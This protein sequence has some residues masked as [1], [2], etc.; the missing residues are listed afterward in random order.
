MKALNL[1]TATLIVTVSLFCSQASAQ[2]KS[3]AA[4][5]Q[6]QAGLEKNKAHQAEMKK[7]YDAMS[8]A[9]QAEARKRADEYKK[10][11]YKN[12]SAKGSTSTTPAKKTT[13]APA[14]KPAQKSV[15][16]AKPTQG[17]PAATANQGTS[18][19]KP[20]FLDANGKPL[21]TTS[22][23][24]NA[25]PATSPSKTTPPAKPATSQ[26]EKAVQTAPSAGSIKK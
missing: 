19:T 9:E 2:S 17:K 14:T 11:G 26:T 22:P 7:K 12:K 15:N 24:T 4:D 8:P 13:S 25:K 10:G 18:K 5:P 16:Q 21:T 1:F 23:A 6:K 20:V 3:I